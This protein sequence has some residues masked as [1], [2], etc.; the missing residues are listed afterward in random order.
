MRWFQCALSRMRTGMI[1]S[2]AKWR[3]E[4]SFSR[5]R[6]VYDE[7]YVRTFFRDRL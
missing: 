3:P 5:A 1:A 2:L 4:P 6:Y 7:E